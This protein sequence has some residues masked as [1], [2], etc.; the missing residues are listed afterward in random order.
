MES[1]H[2]RRTQRAPI[3]NRLAID[4]ETSAANTTAQRFKLQ[5]DGLHT[6]RHR[7]RRVAR[8]L[9]KTVVKQL[10]HA[11]LD[12]E[13]HAAR[14]VTQRPKHAFVVRLM[15]DVGGDAKTPVCHQWH[16]NEAVHGLSAWQKTPTACHRWLHLRRQ[17]LKFLNWQP[18]VQR[19]DLVG[20][21]CLVEGL[22]QFLQLVRMLRCQ[23]DAFREVGV[24]T[25]Q[26]PVVEVKLLT[27]FLD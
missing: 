15:L 4:Q 1:A 6:G 14:H 20:P 5:R 11:G 22:D 18:I 10:Q 13:H 25:V 24:V 7:N 3:A 27:E 12:I 26:H 2:Q 21:G 19:V 16:E 23:V 8:V 17:L 9:T